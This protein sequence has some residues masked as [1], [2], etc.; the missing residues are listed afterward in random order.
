M[1]DAGFDPQ[2]LQLDHEQ[3]PELRWLS[4]ECLFVIEKRPEHERA[5][6]E[7]MDS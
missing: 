4:A 3:T 2:G 6:D 5:T 7:V 1:P